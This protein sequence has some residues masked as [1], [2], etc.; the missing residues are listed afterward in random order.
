MTRPG[1]TRGIL[2]ED[3]K[4]AKKR[5]VLRELERKE[6]GGELDLPSAAAA[7]NIA[8]LNLAR[9][10]KGHL[11]SRGGLHKANRASLNSGLC[12]NHSGI[13]GRFP[14]SEESFTKPKAIGRWSE[15]Q[16]RGPS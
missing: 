15:K 11:A 1:D 14:V 3:G 2:I 16:R 12:A 9:R 10:M 4:V 7:L 13:V 8:P 6:S 5:H